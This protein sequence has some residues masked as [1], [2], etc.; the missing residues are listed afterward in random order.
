[1]KFEP[2]IKRGRML[3]SMFQNTRNTSPPNS[4]NESIMKNTK[5]SKNFY[6]FDSLASSGFPEFGPPCT[7]PGGALFDPNM[8]SHVKL[9]VNKA[10]KRPKPIT[11]P[12]FWLPNIE[13]LAPSPNPPPL[14]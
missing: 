7:P 4:V 10:G 2:N 9:R 12:P 5:M 14:L 11:N 13:L 6:K 1:M 3:K 8:S